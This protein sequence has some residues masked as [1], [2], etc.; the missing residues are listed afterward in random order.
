ME[1]SDDFD[2][3]LADTTP[4]AQLSTRQ[5]KAKPKQAS[6]GQD[7]DFELGDTFPVTLQA[8]KPAA[9]AAKAEAGDETDF[10]LG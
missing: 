5:T 10:D 9:P 4:A 3:E 7:F 6:A 2:F 8:A 1:L